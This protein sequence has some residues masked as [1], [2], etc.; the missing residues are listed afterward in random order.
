MD[1]HPAWHFVAGL[2]IAGA[3][4][5][6]MAVVRNHFVRRRLI[7]TVVLGVVFIAI[8]TARIGVGAI[9]GLSGVDELEQFGRAFEL[10]V[11]AIALVNLL[12][13]LTCN[14]WFRDGFSDYAPSIVQDGL[15]IALFGLICLY[16]FRR[17][18]SALAGSAIAAAAVG[19][20]LQDTLANFFAG[21]GIQIDRPYRVGQWITVGAFDGIV[22]GVTW[23]ATKIRTKLGNLVVLPNNF[24]AKEAITNYSEPVVP[25]RLIVDVGAAY[26]VAPNDVRD[27]VMTVLAQSSQVLETPPPEVLLY[28][29]GASA[30]T[31]RSRFWISDFNQDEA[32]K[33]EVRRGIYYEFKRRGIE[34]PWPIQVRYNRTETATN[35]PERR[36]TFAQ[37]IANVPV[38]AP[39]AGDVHQALASAARE[40]LYGD[41]EVVVREGDAGSS[42]FIVQRG[43]VVITVGHPPKEVARIEAGGYFGEM[44]LLTG[45]PRSATVTARGDCVVLEIS[46]DAFRTYVR[47]H[48]EVVEPLA[49]AAEARRRELDKTR[50]ETRADSGH[51]ATSIAHKIREFFGLGSGL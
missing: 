14:P 25:T 32:I 13:A 39:L 23:R 26:Q 19:F 44:S 4:I 34:I 9:P 46:A 33:D 49:A 17:N 21:I 15:V 38:L 30:I 24:I 27:A 10:M 36:A 5:A 48:P 31:Y 8:H 7:L 1:Q 35:T 47:S 41:G 42:M 2:A 43:R 12:V 22:T 20:A 28:E 51:G 29:F 6:A 40:S 37:A 45:A 3:A 16:A 50:A 11:G 18:A